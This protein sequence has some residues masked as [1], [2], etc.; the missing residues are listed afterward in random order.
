MDFLV[1]AH[2]VHE[3]L[4][5]AREA[6]RIQDDEVVVR[7]GVLE[8]IKDIVFQYLDFQAVETGV[9]AGSLAGAGGDVH[10]GDLGGTGLGAGEGEAALI[11]EAIEH[12]LP[13]GEAGDIGVGL[14]LVEVEAG[15][16]AVVEVDFEIEVVGSDDEGPGVFAVEHFDAWF[17]ALGFAER[18]IIAQ[19]DG[20]WGEQ[21]D[22]GVAD[23]LAA[24]VHG[25]G[26]RLDGD[27]GAV[28]IDD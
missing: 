24:E 14:E 5:V 16:L 4:F 21:G 20:G 22:E 6:G 2:G 1:A 19:D 12:A 13:F 27:V 26:E 15:F 7:L 8:K 25:E 28:A 23:E 17:H 3:G 10:G 18:G 9:V 11:G